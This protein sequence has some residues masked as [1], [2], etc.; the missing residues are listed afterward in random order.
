MPSQQVYD[1]LVLS[2]SEWKRKNKELINQIDVLTNENA[3]L[4]REIANLRIDAKAKGNDLNKAE[5]DLL[6][7][8]D[9]LVG[10]FMINFLRLFIRKPH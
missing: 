8:M 4:I 2:L 3:G 10:E 9:K 6:A 7:C 1:H 5:H